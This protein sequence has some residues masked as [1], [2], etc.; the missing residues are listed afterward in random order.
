MSVYRTAGP[1]T[2]PIPVEF[3]EVDW[4]AVGCDIARPFTLGLEVNESHMGRA[5]RHVPNVEYVRWMEIA[6]VSHSAALGY[7]RDYH[8]ENGVMWFVRRHEID[9]LGEV[10]EGDTIAIATWV[11]RMEKSRSHREYLVYRP[12]D[13]TKILRG[14]T[15]WVLVSIKTRKP[16]RVNPEMIEKYVPKI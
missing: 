6:A 4:K 1:P 5:I 16:M 2:D 7:T 11:S 10:F 12:S 13:S 9:Y 15:I 3:P 14:T 8:K